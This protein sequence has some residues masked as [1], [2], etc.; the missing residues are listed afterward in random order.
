MWLT[1][2]LHCFFIY[3]FKLLKLYMHPVG[4]EP[5]MSP[6]SLLLQGEEVS[7]EQ[8]LIYIALLSLSITQQ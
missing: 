2:H 8:E 4:F 7:F 1:E 3:L 6:F 5:M